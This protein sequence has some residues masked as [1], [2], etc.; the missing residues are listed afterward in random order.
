MTNNFNKCVEIID[1]DFDLEEATVDLLAS[2]IV[3]IDTESNSRFHYPE[4]LCLVQMATESTVF[5]IDTIQVRDMSRLRGFLEDQSIIKVIHDANYDVQC[6]ARHQGL[7]VRGIFDTSIA[8]RFLGFNS[9]GLE[10]V[11]EGVTGKKIAKN[12]R[13]QR[14]D[15]GKRPLPSEAIDYAANDVRFLAQIYEVL[16][17]RLRSLGRLS[18]V[19]EECE[20]VEQIKYTNLGWESAYLR[21]GTTGNLDGRELAVLKQL[22]QFRESEAIKTHKPPAYILSNEAMIFLAKHP[23]NDLLTVPGLHEGVVARIG[24]GLT[25]AIIAGKN[26]PPEEIFKV[27]YLRKSRQELTRLDRL[28]EWR[29]KVGALVQIEPSLVWPKQSLECLA[30]DPGCFDDSNCMV[31][32]R[33][34]Q[35]QEFGETLRA[36]IKTIA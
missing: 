1:R 26:A 27:P 22:C 36:F 28:K 16:E 23:E 2:R 30:E 15:W 10:S 14:S 20:R 19:L 17:K 33:K 18:W 5:L 31:N 6:F 34:W 25:R 21:M 4:Q 3:G 9:F 12:E 29:T 8:A 7:K 32:V 11:V 35:K 13:L 24:A